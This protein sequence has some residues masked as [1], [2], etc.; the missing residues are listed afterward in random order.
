MQCA[1]RGRRAHNVR[2]A[3]AALII[4]TSTA[5]QAATT[6]R[7]TITTTERGKR[8]TVVRRVI[9]DGENR[10]LTVEQQEAPFTYDVLL[11][12]DGGKNTTAL[13]TPLRTW[14]AVVD[15]PP[16]GTGLPPWMSAEIKDT[17]VSVAEEPSEMF[18]G[19]PVRKFVIRAGYTTREN[20][21]GTKVNRVHTMTTLLW[22]TDKLERSLAFPIPKVTFG[23]R[24]IDA[25]LLL[26]TTSISG[27]PL[28]EVTTISR[29]YEGGEPSV[30]MTTFEVDDIRTVPSP[31]ASQFTRPAEYINQEP[32]I[33]S[34]GKS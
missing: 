6:Y 29:A 20:Y 8:P 24:S 22:T 25:E 9:A 26:K 4:I 34:P 19:Y 16:T 23:V 1:K 33:G 12:T 27:F 14:Y 7:V 10:R 11:S 28:R 32:I 15:R 31:P 3:I 17:K 5:L 13:N 30:T 21:S 18:A 2:S